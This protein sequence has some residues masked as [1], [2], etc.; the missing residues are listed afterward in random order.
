M[1][2]MNTN[3]NATQVAPTSLI[4]S[5]SQFRAP[6]ECCEVRRMVLYKICKKCISCGRA[7]RGR[8]AWGALIDKK[9]YST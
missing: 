6:P 8:D 2:N 7:P 3:G 4:K 5:V 9:S 1:K